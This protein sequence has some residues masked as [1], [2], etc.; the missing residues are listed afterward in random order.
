ME[1]AELAADSWLPARLGLEHILLRQTLPVDIR[2]NAK[3][4]REQVA[5]WAE[6]KLTAD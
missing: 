3:I 1:L 5:V 2:H 4:F 6:K